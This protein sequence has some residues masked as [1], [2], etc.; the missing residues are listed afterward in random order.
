VAHAADPNVGECLSASES[1]IRL[2]AD[3]KL[4]GARAQL[5]LCSAATCPAHVRDECIRQL[6]EVNTS[7]PTVVFAVTTGAGEELSAV[8]ITMD[9]EVLV[10]R[11]DGSALTLDPGSHQFT[12]EAAG[13][14]PVVETVILHESEKGRRVDVVVGPRAAPPVAPPAPPSPEPQPAPA[15]L[16]AATPTSPP[17]AAP[18]PAATPA[19]GGKSGLATV[20]LVVGGAGVVGLAV[21]AIF[22]GMASSAWN[23]ARQECPAEAG[24]G[25]Q[26]TSDDKNASK[27]ATVSTATF[28]AGGVLLAGGLTLYLVAPRDTTPSVGFRVMPGGLTVTGGF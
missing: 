18:S 19:S 20:G 16:A 11:L 5:L 1:S 13:Q 3:H 25:V 22:G 8:K 4:R 28:I 10:E 15:P 14:P 6:D 17:A 2:R 7:L 21:G 9:D 26:A 24:C 12:F 27:F 23:K